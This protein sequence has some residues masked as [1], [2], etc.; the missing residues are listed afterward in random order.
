M[1]HDCLPIINMAFAVLISSVAEVLI[2][3]RLYGYGAKECRVD[4][5]KLG[6]V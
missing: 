4:P 3:S 1:S 5:V 6:E 2:Y